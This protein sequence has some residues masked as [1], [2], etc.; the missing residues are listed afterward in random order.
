MRRLLRTT[1][2][3]VILVE[4]IAFLSG[5]ALH[6]GVPLPVPFTESRSLLIALFEAGSGVVL[7]VAA[8]AIAA[9]KPSA[10]KLAVAGHV[11]GVAGI[12][13]GIGTRGAT[14]AAASSHHKPMLLFLIVA[15]IALSAPVCRQA[16]ENGKHRPR[17]RKRPVQAL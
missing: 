10:W 14:F 1:I 12:T 4:A 8:R 13:W 17:R 2:G 15:L 3:I 9:R 11:S 5:A 16:L 6:L 7:L